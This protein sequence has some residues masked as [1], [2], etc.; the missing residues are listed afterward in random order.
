VRGWP[1]PLTRIGVNVD[2]RGFGIGPKGPQSARNWRA[3]ARR[4]VV[5]RLKKGSAVRETE[6]DPQL[7]RPACANLLSAPKHEKAGSRGP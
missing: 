2:S 4:R 5:G 6:G 1:P 7:V 3:L